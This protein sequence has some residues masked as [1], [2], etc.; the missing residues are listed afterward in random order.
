MDIESEEIVDEIIEENNF[1]EF[2][3]ID[4]DF[5]KSIEENAKRLEEAISRI[6]NMEVKNGDKRIFIDEDNSTNEIFLITEEEVKQITKTRTLRGI[7]AIKNKITNFF[8][9][10]FSKE[11]ENQYDEFNDR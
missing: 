8:K 4:E 5:K 7:E 3:E 2:E 9:K 10:M 11:E 1:Q 6:E